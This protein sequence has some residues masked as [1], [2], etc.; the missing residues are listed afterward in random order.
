MVSD[1]ERMNKKLRRKR[2]LM[3]IRLV[4]ITL[5]AVPAAV[6]LLRVFLKTD[7]IL[8]ENPTP[9]SSDKLLS[10][11]SSYIGKTM[12]DFEYD[13]EKLF[14]SDEYPYIKS[15][16][17]K[18][19]FPDKI[20]IK[21]EKTVPEI[22]VSTGDG[23]YIYLDA[24]KKVLEIAD[25]SCPGTLLVTGMNLEEYSVGS[26]LDGNI[27]YEVSLIDN[28]VKVLREHSLYSRLTLLDFEKK[29]DIYFVLDSMINV[30]IGDSENLEEKVEMLVN[31]LAKNT[32]GEKA[33]I[34]VKNYKEGRYRAVN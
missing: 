34:N 16:V 13:P 23:K 28:I 5:I 12:L 9:Y 2:R 32:S 30:Q 4:F 27:N 18:L 29:Y 25:V 20:S 6:V 14:P 7:A 21:L 33:V 17:I 19:V 15:A 26:V 31:I 11:C 24:D 10:S 1:I 8:I 22:S 3:I